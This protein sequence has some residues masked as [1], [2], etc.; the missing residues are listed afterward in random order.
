MS[1]LASERQ[2][3]R[4]SATVVAL[5]ADEGEEREPQDEE[6]L[7]FRDQSLT[8]QQPAHHNNPHKKKEVK[9][10]KHVTAVE[11]NVRST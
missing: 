9:K 8:A 11:R 10:D 5:P 6:K 2:L 4:N 3:H 7:Q 1:F